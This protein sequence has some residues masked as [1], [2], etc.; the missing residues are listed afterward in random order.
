MIAEEMDMS[1]AL[2]HNLTCWPIQAMTYLSLNQ[3]K[4]S[5][6]NKLTPESVETLKTWLRPDYLLYNYFLSKFKEQVSLYAEWLAQTV[7]KLKL[8]NQKV[9]SDCVISHTDNNNGLKGAFR[10]WSSSSLGYKINEKNAWCKYYA[11]SEMAYTN[12]I[13]QDHKAKKVWD[14]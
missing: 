6:K 3:R 8:E 12:I 5:S 10:M 11:I 9:H 2:L 4:E 1:L 13:R 7:N 14:L